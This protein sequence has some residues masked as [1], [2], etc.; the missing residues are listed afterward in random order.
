MLSEKCCD[1]FICV[2]YNLKNIE[3][4]LNNIVQT[5]L[6]KSENVF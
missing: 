4:L 3:L 1:D 5:I 6:V 2:H